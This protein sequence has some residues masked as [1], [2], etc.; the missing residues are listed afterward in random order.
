[1]RSSVQSLRAPAPVR[2]NA[3]LV[4]GRHY[5]DVGLLDISLQGAIVQTREP[6][7]LTAGVSC[8][9]RVL[10]AGGYQ[11]FEAEAIIARFGEGRA[12]LQFG[13][14]HEGMRRAL[15]D[16]M[17]AR[18]GGRLELNRSLDALCRCEQK[19]D[20]GDISSTSR[21]ISTPMLPPAMTS[22]G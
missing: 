19:T 14:P 20:Q 22:V 10:S 12:V 11:A 8:A 18:N 13:A 7:S 5:I 6:V 3:I 1:M 15:E 17:G 4:C 16:F 2:P 21:A 9:L